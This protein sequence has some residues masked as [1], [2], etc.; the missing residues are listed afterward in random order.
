[1]I[2]SKYPQNGGQ[3][4]AI[5][6]QPQPSPQLLMQQASLTPEFQGGV[7][8]EARNLIRD[9]VARHGR[10]YLSRPLEPAEY[11]HLIHVAGYREWG[12]GFAIR[13]AQFLAGIHEDFEYVEGFARRATEPVVHHAWCT[14]NG[15]VLDLTWRKPSPWS[16]KRFG[17]NVIGTIPA[18]WEYVGVPFSREIVSQQSFRW[19][20]RSVLLDKV[21]QSEGEHREMV[22]DKAATPPTNANSTIE[23]LRGLLPD[24][25]SA[26]RAAWATDAIFDEI[27]WGYLR[28]HLGP[29]PI[30][31]EGRRL[32]P[33][34]K[35]KL[36]W[37]LGLALQQLIAVTTGT[38]PGRVNM[39][40][41]V[42][43]VGTELEA[44]E[45]LWGEG[46]RTGYLGVWHPLLGSVF[47]AQLDRHGEL[48]RV[49]SLKYGPWMNT[50]LPGSFVP[51]R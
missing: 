42:A 23:L 48:E 36:G 12:Q 17:S 30:K 22:S 13:N 1:M 25:T 39:H 2:D 21:C 38:G 43:L 3:M 28:D 19:R 8:V 51:T 44:I 10:A 29:P 40:H 37:W 15:K 33:G 14:L 4:A 7:P 5:A 32:A 18:G 50:L 41:P 46:M 27:A 16:R 6:G 49:M 24:Q 9:Y 26:R 45:Q 11:E 35:F 47:S 20:D 31:T 34:E